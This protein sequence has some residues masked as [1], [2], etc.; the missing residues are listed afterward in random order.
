MF[1]NY[2][3][4]DKSLINQRTFSKYG[5]TM[6]A[7]PT[8]KKHIYKWCLKN[9]IKYSKTIGGFEFN[10]PMDYYLMAICWLGCR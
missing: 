8:I 9:E 6:I 7:K 3:D 1:I 10:D 5:K 2:K 4:I